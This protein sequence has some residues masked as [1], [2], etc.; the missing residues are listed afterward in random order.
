MQCEIILTLSI[1]GCGYGHQRTEM[2]LDQLKA[3]AESP[4]QWNK[5]IESMRK[6]VI[7]VIANAVEID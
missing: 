1:D 7:E 5:L 2:S 4:E 3:T 6:D